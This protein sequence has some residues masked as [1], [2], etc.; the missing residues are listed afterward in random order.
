MRMA[1]SPTRPL[2]DDFMRWLA[3][4]DTPNDP[5]LRMRYGRLMDQFHLG[6]KHVRGVPSDAVVPPD[7]FRDDELR[8]LRVPTLLLIGDCDPIC[9]PAAAPDRAHT[10]VPSFEGALVPDSGH[11]MSYSC[12]VDAR[13]LAFLEED[14]VNG[15][16]SRNSTKSGLRCGWVNQGVN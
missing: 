5:A 12:V 14:R 6:L 2:T 1:A 13:I 10:L 4:A 7:M 9:D 8:S 16:R 15:R 3:W 11:M